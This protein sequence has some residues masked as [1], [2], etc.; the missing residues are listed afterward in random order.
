MD[1]KFNQQQFFPTE[2]KY[3]RNIPSLDLEKI[4]Q[5]YPLPSNIVIPDHNQK[6]NYKIQK[7]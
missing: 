7:L 3:K 1:Y 2:I 4:N 6:H 5:Q